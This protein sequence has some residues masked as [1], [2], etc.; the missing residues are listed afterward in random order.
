MKLKYFNDTDTLLMNLI[1]DEVS[2]TREL[3]SNTFAD[4]NK[5]GELISLTIEY[6]S[7][8]ND[9]KIEFDGFTSQQISGRI[10]E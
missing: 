9:N 3:N 1:D 4:F 7:K 2:E 8:N 6:F 5:Q 10:G